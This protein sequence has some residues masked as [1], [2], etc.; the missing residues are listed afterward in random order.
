MSKLL[1]QKWGLSRPPDVPF[2]INLASPQAT[3]LVAW[4]PM[5][6][7][8][9]TNQLRDFS[10]HGHPGTFPGGGADPTWRLDAGHGWVLDFDGSNDYIDADNVLTDPSK[11]WTMA[12]WFKLHTLDQFLL[13][14]P[15]A[16]DDTSTT[17]FI[18]IGVLITN[19]DHLKICSNGRTAGDDGVPVLVNTWY[20]AGIVWDGTDFILYRDG[21]Y[22]Y[23][24]TPSTTAWIANLD[25][26]RL[27]RSENGSNQEYTDGLIADS[28]VWDRG[29]N[30][31]EFWQLYDKATRWELYKPLVRQWRPGAVAPPPPTVALPIFSSLDAIHSQVFGGVTVR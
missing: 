14:M 12:G 7:S 11:T 26:F 20:H 17:E 24:V 25:Q 30:A 9:G 8:A 18:S 27:G 22:A 3:G 19:N 2:E 15:I 5:L 28:R 13:P 10:D 4:W 23:Q 31:A 21:H 16:Q 6:A 1:R 29:L